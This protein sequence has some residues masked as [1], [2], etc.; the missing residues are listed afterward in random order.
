MFCN[1]WNRT[2][3]SQYFTIGRK[4]HNT[5]NVPRKVSGNTIQRVSRDKFKG[6]RETHC[7][8]IGRKEQDIPSVPRWIERNMIRPVF[9]HRWNETLYSQHSAIG[10]ME[11]DIALF[12]ATSLPALTWYLGF[13]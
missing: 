5:A 1:R 7:F 13:G 9:R 6:T 2:R 4:K 12:R 3:Y 8:A 10:L 11:H